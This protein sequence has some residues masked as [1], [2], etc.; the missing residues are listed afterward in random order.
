MFNSKLK[1]INT[2]LMVFLLI[3]VFKPKPAQA[4]VL[5]VCINAGTLN[6]RSSPEITHNNDIGDLYK[7]DKLVLIHWDKTG[8][9][10]YVRVK[11]NHKTGWVNAKYI[12][13]TCIR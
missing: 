8:H 5:E 1:W 13:E 6:I 12:R 3:P 10:A 9:W 2:I 11:K 4:H 7:Y